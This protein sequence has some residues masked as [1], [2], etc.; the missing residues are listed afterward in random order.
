MAPDGAPARPLAIAHRAGNRLADLSEAFAA[1]ADYV[2][3]DVWLH[4]GR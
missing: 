1:G 2:E 4:R 3:T